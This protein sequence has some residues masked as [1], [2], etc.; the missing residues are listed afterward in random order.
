MKNDFIGKWHGREEELASMQSAELRRVDE[1]YAAG[2]YDTAN[3]TVG[4]SIGLINDIPRA[5]DLVR[6]ISDEARAC[7]GQYAPAP[8][9]EVAGR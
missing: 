2:D 9:E 3:V 7:L 6:R 1:A 4:E 5:A 8:A